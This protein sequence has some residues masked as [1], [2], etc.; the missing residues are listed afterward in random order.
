MRRYQSLSL[1]VCKFSHIP[2]QNLPSLHSQ[3]H[4]RIHR[5]DSCTAL[6]YFKDEKVHLSVAFSFC[7]LVW[8]VDIFFFFFF[9]HYCVSLMK[10]LGTISFGLSSLIC[11]YNNLHSTKQRIVS[12]WP[13]VKIMKLILDDLYH[14]E[15]I[16]HRRRKGKEF[17]FLS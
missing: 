3:L 11:L 1:Y 10:R 9:C 5:S 12:V 15:F 6:A 8:L 2:L 17:S 7:P 4:F 13:T 14:K 16:K